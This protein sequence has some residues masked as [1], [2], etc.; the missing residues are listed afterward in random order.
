MKIEKGNENSI[1]ITPQTA[2]E[3]NFIAYLTCA[4]EAKESIVI[5]DVGSNHCVATKLHV[6]DDLS[7][8]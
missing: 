7:L 1:I 3:I 6:Q 8:I 2:I 4:L 5:N